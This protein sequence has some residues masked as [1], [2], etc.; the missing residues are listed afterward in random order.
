[1]QRKLRIW[2]TDEAEGV[3]EEEEEEKEEE[4][5]GRFILLFN[6]TTGWRSSSSGR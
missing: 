2:F 1:M 4:D 5:E 6:A 3:E